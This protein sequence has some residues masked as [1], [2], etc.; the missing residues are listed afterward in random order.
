M[1]QTA[2]EPWGDV[3]VLNLW[4]FYF[5]SISRTVPLTPSV[6][7]AWYDKAQAVFCR[8]CGWNSQ[9]Q[10]AM[11]WE[12][13]I[14]LACY[15]CSALA[16]SLWELWNWKKAVA[17]MKIFGWRWW[18]WGWMG[19]SKGFVLGQLARKARLA[20]IL[21]M[22]KYVNIAVILYCQLSLMNES[23]SLRDLGSEVCRFIQK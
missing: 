11:E 20:E 16:F 22:Y 17:D 18:L 6:N 5:L 9:L 7:W 23:C 12:S 8:L 1:I 4:A 19:L 3:A 10:W 14:C 13:C 21:M 15:V 2:W